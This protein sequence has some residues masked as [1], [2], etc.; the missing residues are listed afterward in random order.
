MHPAAASDFAS[1]GRVMLGW[2]LRIPPSAPLPQ[3]AALWRNVLRLLSELTAAGAAASPAQ[4]ADVLPMLRFTPAELLKAV[5]VSPPW[6][7]RPLEQQ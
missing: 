6:S 5:N 4:E 1:A 3:T 7:F 2:L